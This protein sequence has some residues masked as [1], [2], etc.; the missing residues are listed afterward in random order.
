MGIVHE[1]DHS[2]DTVRSGLL[3]PQHVVE[4]LHPEASD[5]ELVEVPEKDATDA[6]A[7]S[8]R[9]NIF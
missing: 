4:A 7:L 2:Q 1:Y 3:T 5:R 9:G 8:P 6:V